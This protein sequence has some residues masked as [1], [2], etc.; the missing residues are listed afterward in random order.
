M[1]TITSLFPF[2]AVASLLVLL[3]A[4]PVPM[5]VCTGCTYKLVTFAAVPT[6]TIESA[7]VKAQV[8]HVGTC[9]QSRFPDGCTESL[10]Y[11]VKCAVTPGSVTLPLL[12]DAADSNTNR[13][14]KLSV[15]RAGNPTPTVIT[16][17]MASGAGTSTL[18]GT[19]CPPP[20]VDPY[21]MLPD[22][23]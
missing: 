14:A 8:K 23:L 19:P 12:I 10:S 7:S 5:R 1:R 20:T 11:N 6:G 18:P 21:V 3:T 22:V 16:G 15:K 2:T 9:P 17:T 4:C 13:S